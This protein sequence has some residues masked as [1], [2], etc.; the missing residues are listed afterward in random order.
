M[1]RYGHIA[2]VFLQNIANKLDT[3][4]ADSA[5]E[6]KQILIDA[7]K[8]GQVDV[9]TVPNPSNLDV[10]LS[11]RSSES[12]LEAVRAL[13][14]SL[15]NALVSVGTDKLRISL[16]DSLAVSRKPFNLTFT[17]AG[18]QAA[19][20][21]ASGKKVRLHFI[22]FESNADVQVGWR[23]GTTETAQACRVTKGIYAVN[24]IGC[25]QE[26]AVDQALNIRA[27]GAVTVKG[28]MLGQEI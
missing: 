25:N 21:P 22:S 16:V 8:H 4:D 5:K 2:D 28:Y 13:L 17:A 27:E 14:D 3:L 19:W 23:F 9:L 24:L 11:T 20:T 7:D 1:P 15:E 10:A 26:G 6:A 18:D 12:K